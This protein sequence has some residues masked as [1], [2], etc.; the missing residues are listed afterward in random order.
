MHYSYQIK[1]SKNQKCQIRQ[2]TNNRHI[3]T[4]SNNLSIVNDLKTL[5]MNILNNKAVFLMQMD[6]VFIKEYDHIKPRIKPKY[7]IIIL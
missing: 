1:Q 5:E 3:N 2:I 7:F 4:N 6:C